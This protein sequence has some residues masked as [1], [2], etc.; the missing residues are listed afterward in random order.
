MQSSGLAQTT[1][2]PES[3]RIFLFR[4]QHGMILSESVVAYSLEGK[5]YLSVEEIF[6]L[7]SLKIDI[8]TNVSTAKGFIL[9][10]DNEFHIDFKNCQYEL[11]KKEYKYPCE[12][13]QIVDSELF[14]DSHLI[15]KWIDGEFTVKPFKSEMIL[16]SK[17][18]YPIELKTLRSKTTP[19]ARPKGKKEYK[20]LK[21]FK[22]EYFGGSILEQQF[23]FL[24]NRGERASSLDSKLMLQLGGFESKFTQVKKENA[25]TN[26]VELV[27]KSSQPMLLGLH[28]IKLLD[29]SSPSIKFISSAE[30]IEGFSFSSYDHHAGASF[31]TQALEGDLKS[32]WEVELYYLGVLTERFQSNGSGR[33]IFK[34]VPVQY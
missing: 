14:V 16:H 4:F 34:D 28:E 15:E 10:E 12:F 29:I 22:P 31:S 9:S 23:A 2:D 27:R 5:W 30:K 32:G 33:Y 24:N 8:S 18:T 13:T 26:S 1:I 25:E 7:L 19:A 20:N 6:E 21:I 11:N 3:E 17:L